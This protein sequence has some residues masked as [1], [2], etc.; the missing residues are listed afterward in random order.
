MTGYNCGFVVHNATQESSE[1]LPSNLP[2]SHHNSDTV[3]WREEDRI[4]CRNQNQNVNVNVQSKT[5]RKSVYSTALS[6]KQNTKYTCILQMH[7]T[8]QNISEK[9]NMRINTKKTKVMRISQVEGRPMGQNLEKVKQ[10][11]YLGRLRKRMVK[12]F[13]W[14]VALYGSEMWTLQKEDIR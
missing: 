1:N 4:I 5:D 14:G 13:V 11:C 7:C 12:L 8:V 9:Y 6:T 3:Y 10:F 2:D